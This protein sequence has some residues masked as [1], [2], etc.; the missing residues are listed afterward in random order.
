MMTV[1]QIRNFIRAGRATFTIESTKS[2]KHYTFHAAA[3]SDGSILWIS[4]LTGPDEY[5]Y[6]G[7]LLPKSL[8]YRETPKSPP[9]H[10]LHGIL[11]W[12]FLHLR[13]PRLHPMLVFRHQ[14][15]CGRCGREL[16]TPESIDTGLGPICSE[17]MG[18]PH[19][20]ARSH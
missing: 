17:R 3:K 1:D 20:R 8:E 9:A 4:A 16:T 18:I 10:N 11:R 7:K 15:N 13:N 2:G 19:E 5:T 12:F 14:G 6:M